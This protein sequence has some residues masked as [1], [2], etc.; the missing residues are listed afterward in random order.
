MPKNMVHSTWNDLFFVLHT[1]A[2][3]T[4]EEWASYMVTCRRVPMERMRSFI[5][6]DG[7]SPNA[8]QRQEVNDNLKGR[9]SIAAVVSGSAM[10]RGVVT[11]LT[12]FNA[13]I[14]V[15]SPEE[16]VAALK[17]LGLDKREDLEFVWKT[18]LELK[19]QLGNQPLAS[20]DRF[21]ANRPAA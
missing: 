6:T 15:F 17:Y 10:V 7:G 13:G 1:G 19:I 5:I 3:P 4:E 2:M 9:K 12:W 8:K 14:K 11:A 16:S 21:A 18:V 20:L